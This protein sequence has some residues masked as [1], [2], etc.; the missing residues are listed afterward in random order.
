MI[1]QLAFGIISLTLLASPALGA[2]PKEKGFFIGGAFGTTEFDDDGAFSWLRFDDTDTSITLSAGY[3]FFRYFAVEARYAD[4][5]TY[6][7]SSGFARESFDLSVVSAHAVGIIPFGQSGWEIYGQ[8]GLGRI[9]VEC[10][11]CGDE[12]AGSA[13]L[14]V[15]FSPAAQFAVGVQIDAYAWEE[16]DFDRTYDL[17]VATI[18]LAFQY[19]F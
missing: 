14:G 18:Q 3:K 15:R 16:D 5:G 12:T 7:I 1:K 9:D 4:L 13:G 6:T 8:L 10:G 17:S 19:L 11:G 2:A